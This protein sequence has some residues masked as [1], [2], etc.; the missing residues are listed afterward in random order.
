[1]DSRGLIAFAENYFLNE[2][3]WASRK[4]FQGTGCFI[5]IWPIHDP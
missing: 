2:G 3:K 5:A 1:M 4:T